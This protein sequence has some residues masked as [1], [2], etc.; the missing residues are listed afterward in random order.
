MFKLPKSLQHWGAADFVTIFKGEVA[1]LNTEFLPLQQALTYSSQVSHEKISAVV[2]SQQETDQHLEIKCGIFFTGVI[3]GCSCAD[4]PTPLDT[5]NE[6][7]ELLFTIDKN[8]A[9][10]SVRL[11]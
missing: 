3:A 11:L 10:T 9:N 5:Q 1:A 4:D 8:N 2:M 6:H 7:C